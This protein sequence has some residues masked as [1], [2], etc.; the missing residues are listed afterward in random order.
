MMGGGMFHGVSRGH[1]DEEVFGD[2]YDQ[3]VVARLLPYILPYKRLTAI[4]FV[5]MLIY[6][7]TQVA[8]PWIIAVSIDQY[9]IPKDI[10]GL[11]RMFAL[12][13]GIAVVN[14]AAHYIQQ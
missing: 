3:R 4:A 7:G 1:P 6:T 12:S 5:S 2:V 8:I 11:T 14:W 10:T 13:R 9:I